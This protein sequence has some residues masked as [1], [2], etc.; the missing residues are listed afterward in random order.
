MK[1]PTPLQLLTTVAGLLFLFVIIGSLLRLPPA[2]PT[3]V[4]YV[5]TTD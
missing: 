2:A 3:R 5:N 1:R 4:V